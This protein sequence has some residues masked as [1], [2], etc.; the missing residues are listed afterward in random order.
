MVGRDAGILTV[1]YG[2][3]TLA[4]FISLAT[5]A[6]TEYLVDVRTSPYSRFKPEFSR[7]PLSAE[8]ERHGIRYVFMGATLGGRPNDPACYDE[9]GRVDYRRCRV[10][11]A[12][13]EGLASLEVGWEAGHRLTLM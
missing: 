3:R 6:E 7:K 2:R 4:E 9:D 13:L 10:R 11:P 12:F 8:L 1:G 5:A